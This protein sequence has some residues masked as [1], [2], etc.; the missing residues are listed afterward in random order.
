MAKSKTINAMAYRPNSAGATRRASTATPSRFAS[1]RR[2]ADHR[3]PES[4]ADRR[5]RSPQRRAFVSRRR[6]EIDL[7]PGVDSAGAPIGGLDTAGSPAASSSSVAGGS[8][9]ADDGTTLWSE[10]GGVRA[11]GSV[12]VVAR[13]VGKLIW[14]RWVPSRF[15]AVA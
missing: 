3:P 15:A 9:S 5:R 10:K 12:P 2:S 1:R 7:A 4:G 6:A 14:T 13:A 11:S 8:G